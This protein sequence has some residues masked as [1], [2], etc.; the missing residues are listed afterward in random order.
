MVA[1]PVRQTDAITAGIVNLAG[2]EG[3]RH[4]YKPDCQQCEIRTIAICSVFGAAEISEVQKLATTVELGPGEVLFEQG[5]PATYVYN[6][7]SGRLR[8]FTLLTDGRRQ[9][10]N[11]AR[12]GEFLGFAADDMRHSSAEAITQVSACRF[13]KS[14][15]AQLSER[16]PKICKRILQLKERELE[17][18]QGQLVAV[19]RKS[20]VE[21]VASFLCSELEASGWQNSQKPVI[22]LQMTRGD[23]ADYLGLTIETVSRTFTKLR[24]T[25]TISLP[26]AER[27]M[28]ED[29]ERL[30]DFQES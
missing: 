14:D 21:R 18:T 15:L 25:G 27:V 19:G 11:F 3:C 26:R 6:L 10:T 12:P 17:T 5:D 22:E 20:P 28:V 30:R 29:L 7:V 2:V 24:Q 16:H 23:I 4:G 1:N 8:L 13:V 9:I